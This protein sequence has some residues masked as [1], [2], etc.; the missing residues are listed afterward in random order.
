MRIGTDASPKDFEPAVN[1]V[2]GIIGAA[3]DK[4]VSKFEARERKNPLL[5]GHFREHFALEFALAMARKRRKSTGHLPT[6]DEYAFLYGFL[7]PA[8]RIH[9]A[10]PQEVRTTFEGR[11]R[12]AVTDAH[13]FRPF[14]YEISIAMHLMHKAWDIDF[15]D[16]SGAARFDLLARKNAVEIEIECKST[17]GDTGRKIHRQEVNRLADVLLPTTDQLADIVVATACLSPCLVGSGHQTKNCPRSHPLP[18][19]Q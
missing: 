3:L 18:P 1:W 10:L 9:A 19:W 5:T 8:H 17:S 16:Y 4:R 15:I 12:N 7:V 14:A 11:L 2:S 6:G 13:G